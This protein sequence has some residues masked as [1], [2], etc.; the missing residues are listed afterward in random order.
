MTSK[1]NTLQNIILWLGI[2]GTAAALAVYVYIGTFT[3]YM[4]DDYCLLVDLNSGSILTASYEKYL[5]SSNR[6]ANLFVIGVSEL[7]GARSTALT[8]GV[9]I[10]SWVAGLTWLGHEL[11]KLFHLSISRPVVLLGA[12]L[13]AV[14]TLYQLPNL[15]Q[16]V[17]WR[18]GQVTYFTPLVLF[19]FVAAGL[20]RA[21]RRPAGRSLLWLALLF[22]ILAFFIGGLSETLGAFHI[23]ALGMTILAVTLRDHSPRRR[24]ALVLLTATLAGALLALLAMYY[25]PANALRLDENDAARS[26]S[27]LILRVLQYSYSFNHDTWLTRPVPLL[28]ALLLAFLLTFVLIDDTHSAPARAWPGLIA[29][30]L[31]HFILIMAIVAPS[32]YGQSYPVERVRLPAH[33]SLTIALMSLGVCLAV[34]ARSVRMPAV[35]RALAWLP[36]ATLLLYPLW[37]ARQTLTIAG[38][39]RTWSWKWDQRELFIYGLIAAGQT[40]LMIPALPGMYSTKEL[41]V[42]PEYWVNRCAAQYYGVNSIR[43][44]PGPD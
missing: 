35:V 27:S 39:L 28:A 8:P 12:E 7:L 2:L 22:A 31:L 19:T 37:T 33:Y 4:A 25:S 41:D 38:D 40:D 18:P 43:A 30:P 15:F 10:L 36:L 21:I 1:N 11:R 34:L 14:I 6:F 29:I 32:A 5:A 42:R 16:S 23:T 3:R 24:P 26:L 17:Y 9:L 44:I 13:T 20:I